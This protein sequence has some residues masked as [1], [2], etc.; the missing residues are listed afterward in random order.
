MAWDLSVLKRALPELEAAATSSGRMAEGFRSQQESL[1]KG[2]VDG[3]LAL[4]EA[5]AALQQSREEAAALRLRNSDL[6]REIGALRRASAV[7][8]SDF[9]PKT[10]QTRNAG[11]RRD[12]TPLSP[13]LQGLEETDASRS[14]G[15][16]YWRRARMC[17]K[18]ASIADY[19][20]VS[21]ARPCSCA[22]SLAPRFLGPL[23]APRF[24]A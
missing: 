13:L 19:W 14:R 2:R 16:A 12:L 10:P 24:L 23:L 3:D 20:Q 21:H 17:L 7:D 15:S 1:A 18:I 9:A 22:A 4:Q 8:V 6:E 5:R 11:P